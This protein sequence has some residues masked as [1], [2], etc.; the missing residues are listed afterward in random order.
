MCLI[1]T[2][3]VIVDVRDSVA[4]AVPGDLGRNREDAQATSVLS[5][6]FQIQCELFRRTSGEARAFWQ[7]SNT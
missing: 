4:M 5:E 1:G 2:I 7:A 6:G 3:A